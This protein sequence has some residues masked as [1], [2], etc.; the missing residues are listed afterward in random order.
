MKGGTR[1][2]KYTE[3]IF[4]NDSCL[5]DESHIV[6][7]AEAMLSPESLSELSLALSAAYGRKEVLTPRGA[8]T[9]LFGGCVP[10]GGK[11][12]NLS[13]LTKLG[14]LRESPL[15][16][17]FR[18]I[19]L[20]CGVTQLELEKALSGSGF[21]FPPDPTEESASIGGIFATGAAGPSSLLYGQSS[22]YISEMKFITKRGTVLELKR[23]KGNE[24]E[25]KEGFGKR[26]SEDGIIFLSEGRQIDT[27]KFSELPFRL[28]GS[29]AIDFLFGSEGRLGIAASF[30]LTLL[31]EPE[32][33]WGV[34]FFFDEESRC[35]S[36]SKKLSALA[37]ANE[38]G[39]GLRAAEFFNYDSLEFLRKNQSCSLLSS[40]PELPA[41]G[42]ALYIEVIGSQE[43]TEELLTLI[44]SAFEE[45][46]GGDDDSWAENGTAGVKRLRTLRHALPAILN[47]TP[48]CFSK[49]RGCRL[50]TDF[51]GAPEDFSEFIRLYEEGAESYGVSGALY[52]H[53]LKNELF[54][55]LFPFD[56]EG[57]DREEACLEL[58][59]FLATRL[60]EKNGLL[61]TEHGAGR[62]KID[63]VQAFL[64]E[65]EKKALREL[66]ESFDF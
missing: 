4:E 55:S 6:G 27:N 28:G 16:D 39:S 41:A 13:R 47:E 37:K 64:S 15:G 36:F 11:I 65:N 53:I 1:P 9:G 23:E 31:R 49:S 26:P 14:K 22:K 60:R 35:I 34:L 48:E 52:G 40:V 33:I 32:D 56:S 54:F 46:G 12:L 62:A 57:E 7:R 66:E 21:F 17:D 25:K 61:I 51:S 45:L 29:D 43:E 5:R 58:I 2:L 24:K 3:E 42:A 44:L 63:C 38:K 8:G 50:E 18:E 30:T 59:G 10:Q 20:E 19:E